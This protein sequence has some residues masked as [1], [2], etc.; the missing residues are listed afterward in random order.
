M[1]PEQLDALERVAEAATPGPWQNGIDDLEGV[2]AP[3]NPGLGNVICTPPTKRM[4]DSIE[5]WPDN[6]THIATFDPPTVKALISLARTAL[7]MPSEE[8]VAS[9][10]RLISVPLEEFALLFAW[11]FTVSPEVPKALRCHPKWPDQS[12]FGRSHAHLTKALRPYAHEAFVALT[13]DKANG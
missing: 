6:A 4:Y 13:R 5:R 2:V 12:E 1:T 3:E 11:C 8:E 9:E 10:R 7:R